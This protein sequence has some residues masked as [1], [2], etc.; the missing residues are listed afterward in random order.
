[1]A[2]TK[3]IIIN[4]AIASY[5]E[6]G[7][8]D[9]I[10][11]LHGWGCAAHTFRDIQSALSRAYK[12][13]AVDFPGFG[14]SEEP[15]EIWGCEEYAR[16]T[17]ELVRKLN[18]Q[19]PIVLGHSFG[20]RVA[21][22]LNSKITIKKL[23]LTGSAGLIMDTDIEKRKGSSKLGLVKGILE[24]TL[25]KSA[26][27]WVKDKTI[28]QMGSADYR[29]AN[30]Q[31]REILKKVIS[32]DLQT[33]AVKVTIPTLLIW[34]ENDQDTPVA[35]GRKFESLMPGSELHILSGTG[36]YAFIDRK[37]EFLNLTERFLNHK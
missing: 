30:P 25:P 31:M 36:H 1:M 3:E 18:I 14:Q 13:Y 29:N 11:L 6:E 26:F 34:G 12:V 7:E 5:T 2:K 9:A 35:M 19:T 33:Y 37:E 21:L 4:G 8:G 17:E 27:D 22:I 20:G 16:W 24:K 23:I 10:L 15:K 28:Q 32:E